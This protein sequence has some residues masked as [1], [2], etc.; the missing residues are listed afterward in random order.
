MAPESSP[1]HFYTHQLIESALSLLVINQQQ[2]KRS[3][4]SKLYLLTL[5]LYTETNKKFITVFFFIIIIQKRK[6]QEIHGW[7]RGGRDV[8]VHERRWGKEKGK[9]GKMHF[10]LFIN[11][12]SLQQ[13][14]EVF[15]FS[16][17]TL[18]IHLPHHQIE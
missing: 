11:F 9:M 6:R 17:L 5:F 3:R 14:N 7:G 4:P 18:F 8:C 10:Y 1:H 16:F 2:S 15:S 12:G 13:K